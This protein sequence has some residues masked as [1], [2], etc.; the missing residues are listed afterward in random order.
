MDCDGLDPT[1]EE[2]YGL[3]SEVT[4]VEDNV[5]VTTNDSIQNEIVR[6]KVF[7]IM[8]NC[9]LSKKAIFFDNSDITI[10]GIYILSYIN[11]QGMILYSEKVFLLN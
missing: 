10:P 9:I 11:E 4:L 6:I 3:K 7:D 5:N 1:C 2:Y 8:G